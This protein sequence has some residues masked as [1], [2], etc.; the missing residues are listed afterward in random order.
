MGTFLGHILPGTFF[1]I[2]GMM[3]VVKDAFSSISIKRDRETSRMSS[4]SSKTPGSP[5]E[6]NREK[7]RC[8]DNNS[9]QPRGKLGKNESSNNGWESFDFQSD[10]EE[11]C[12]FSREKHRPLSADSEYEP[13]PGRDQSLCNHGNSSCS[14]ELGVDEEKMK[15]KHGCERIKESLTNMLVI[16]GILKIACATFGALGELWWGGWYIISPRTG[17]FTNMNNWQHA[18]MFMYFAI[19]GVADIVFQTCLRSSSPS[20]Q[21]IEKIFLSLAFS[22]EGLLFFFHTNGREEIDVHIHTLLVILIFVCAVGAGLEPWSYSPESPG[23]RRLWVI[24]TC[25][26][27]TWFWQIAFVL[28]NPWG[29]KSDLL[30]EERDGDVTENMMIM[31]TMFTWHLLAV[32]ALICLV[33]FMVIYFSRLRCCRN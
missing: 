13:G 11:T 18:T 20:G 15:V 16:E 32:L 25:V 9:P 8:L 24:A 26:Q 1:L 31:T 6:H 14:E 3:Y 17:N 5:R 28:Y 19:S 33:H 23:V 30:N 29:K 21:S 2:Y 4:K 7:K 10:E 12:L 27:G 22:V